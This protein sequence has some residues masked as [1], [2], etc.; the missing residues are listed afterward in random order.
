V[1]LPR[2]A[3]IET[4]QHPTM[5]EPGTTD[6]PSELL[7]RPDEE[8]CCAAFCDVEDPQCEAGLECVEW[9]EGGFPPPLG[10]CILPD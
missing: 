3:P 9:F 4:D 6:V 2:D 10:I 5:C 7:C 8:V 1:C